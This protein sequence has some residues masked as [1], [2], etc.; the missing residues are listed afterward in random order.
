MI[1]HTFLKDKNQP[2]PQTHFGLARPHM[3]SSLESATG[4]KT[5]PGVITTNG[6]ARDFSR[7]PIS[8][9][10]PVTVQAKLAVSAPGSV[11]E[12]EADRVAQQVVSMPEPACACGGACPRCRKEQAVHGQLQAKRVRANDREEMHAPPLVNEVLRSTG[13]PLD[14]STREFMESRFG[15]DFSHVRVHTGERAAESAQ[16]VNALAYTI[17]RDVVFGNAQYAPDTSGGRR[18]LAHELTHV[19]QQSPA[20]TA[21]NLMSKISRPSDAAEVEADRT[22]R[23]V[24]EPDG[25]VR[26]ESGIGGYRPAQVS[27]SPGVIYR[28][29]NLLFPGT[30]INNSKKPVTVW[31]DGA[32]TYTIAAGARSGLFEDVDHI[33]D[34]QGQWYK[35][36]WN[37]VTVDAGGKL[38]GYKCKVSNFGEDCPKQPE[39]DK[40]ERSLTPAVSTGIA[41]RGKPEK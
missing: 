40:P 34:E 24:V 35:I 15:H 32:G 18:L 33:R 13:Q 29:E 26:H 8:A 39:L 1:M 37:T 17:G 2:Q 16:M 19:L 4:S 11:H 36:G 7:V 28:G 21:P 12:Q 31:R 5:A 20:H 23:A 14:P 25:G 22:A 9:K 3:K 10:A 30:V 41:P 27:A 38:K 6:F